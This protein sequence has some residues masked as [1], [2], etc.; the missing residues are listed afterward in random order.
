MEEQKQLGHNIA[1]QNLNI[2]LPGKQG[3]SLARERA[4]AAEKL[5]L[6]YFIQNV[7][8]RPFFCCLFIQKTVIQHFV[9]V[10]SCTAAK[11]NVKHQSKKNSGSF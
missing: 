7:A 9:A 5:L 8:C 6:K 3:L 11:I 2:F 1:S 10:G 4:H